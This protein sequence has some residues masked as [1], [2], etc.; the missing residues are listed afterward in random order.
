ME[1]PVFKSVGTPVEELDTPALVVDI[2]ALDHN[3]ETL[4]SFFR[5][6]DAKVR[7]H[8]EAHRCPAIAH[9]Q[10]AAG[11]TVGGISVTTV[12]EAEVFAQNGFNDIFVANEIVTAAKIGRLCAL[13]RG[14]TVTVAVDS[15][16]NVKDLSEAA[17]AAGVMLSA[18]V[19]VH[20]GGGL[21][22]VEPGAPGVDLARRVS[23]A[24]GLRFAGLTT[25]EG[26]ILRD[27]A[28]AAAEESRRCVQRVLDTR[29]MVE[30]EGMPVEVVSAGATH[31]YEVV[32]A[33]AGVTEVPAGSYALMD[34]RYCQHLE[35]FKA[36][37]KIMS[38]VTSVPDATT[39][40]T[41]CGQKAMGI[42]LGLPVAEDTPGATLARMSAEHGILDLTAEGR[43]N[44]D[45]GD[46]VRLT[47]WDIANCVNVYDYIQATRDGKLEAVW[48]VSAR[49]QYR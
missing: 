28:S 16:R 48:N 42:D 21:C 36:A 43:D 39:A 5:G 40:I 31:S 17:Q 25:Y 2:D 22:G 13:A 4:H 37:A 10:M 44:I 35:G 26:K 45:L 8:V 46:K 33:M 32:G 3:I 12:G 41:D 1:R 49:G 7:P 29:E 23:E 24:G 15:P 18:V 20:T 47:P 14:A 9:R 11:G 6:V 38:T 19:D 27:D 30:K 34:Y